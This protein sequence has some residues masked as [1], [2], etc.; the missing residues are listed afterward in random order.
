[1]EVNFGSEYVTCILLAY[2]LVAAM[3]SVSAGRSSSREVNIG[4]IMIL[5]FNASFCVE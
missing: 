4:F 2:F 1:M 5:F 3:K